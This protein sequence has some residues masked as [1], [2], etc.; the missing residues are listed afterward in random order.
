M[1]LKT[2]TIILV[3]DLVGTFVSAIEGALAAM[4]SHLDL[5][6][7]T[8]VSLGGLVRDL[9]RQT[10]CATGVI[11]CSASRRDCSLSFFAIRFRPC[12]PGR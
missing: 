7:I 6:G 5:L 2:A 3:A 8:V 1:Q 10:P 12:R 11:R 9:R 4:N